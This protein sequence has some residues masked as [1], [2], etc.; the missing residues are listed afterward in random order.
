MLIVIFA[1]CL[2]TT[3][4]SIVHAVILLGPGGSLEGVAVEAEVRLFHFT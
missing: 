3:I 4:V 1:A 2:L